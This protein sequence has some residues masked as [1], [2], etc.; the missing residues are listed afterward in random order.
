MPRLLN[1][2]YKS[3]QSIPH[4]EM[5]ICG[6]P[7]NTLTVEALAALPALVRTFRHSTS[8]LISCLRGHRCRAVYRGDGQAWGGG[9]QE[10]W[11]AC[12][13]GD[14]LN[15]HVLTGQLQH[16]LVDCDHTSSGM[17]CQS[18]HPQSM[19]LDA[20]LHFTRGDRIHSSLKVNLGLKAYYGWVY[21]SN[22]P[23]LASFGKWTQAPV[24]G[25][26]GHLRRR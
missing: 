9:K 3:H 5:E 12:N 17:P 7:L 16:Q 26:A 20:G 25:A 24:P 15:T 4:G 11:R 2:R 14:V 22:M 8:L 21:G 1:R 6:V 18:Y 13:D 23:L 19:Q 10:A